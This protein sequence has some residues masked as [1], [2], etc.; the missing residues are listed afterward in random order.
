MTA[1]RSDYLP[2]YFR[3]NPNFHCVL[4]WYLP[5]DLSLRLWFLISFRNKHHMETHPPLMKQMSSQWIASDAGWF[6][7]KPRN[8]SSAYSV[9]CLGTV[10]PAPASSMELLTQ[11]NLLYNCSSVL[12]TSTP[13]HTHTL[14][15][16]RQ[17]PPLTHASLMN[18][19]MPPPLPL[20]IHELVSAKSCAPTR[21]RKK[22]GVSEWARVTTPACEC[23]H[24]CKSV[25]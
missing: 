16:L 12:I 11:R 17:S 5:L 21:R 6:T 10:S 4:W 8:T 13:A 19:I 24:V 23:V 7:H 3:T 2:D 18:I 20:I 15:P 1:P 25:K 14:L 22:G 9:C